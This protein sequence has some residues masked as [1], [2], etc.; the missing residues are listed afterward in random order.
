M[1][2]FKRLIRGIA[3]LAGGALFSQFPGFY[4]AYLQR[5]GGRL[6]QARFQIVRIEEA[7]RAEGYNIANYIAYFR[8]HDG[9]EERHQGEIMIA[10]H[11]DVEHL[12]AALIALGDASLLERPIRL[13]QHFD[14]AYAR[15]TLEEFELVLPL[16][17]EGAV[18]M[19]L[20]LL[21]GFLL[22]RVAGDV[23]VRLGRR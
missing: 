19:V 13:V 23:L 1:A 8:E 16:T 10:Q 7:A 21:F 22:I 17:A 14:A 20:G 6:D 3:A 15:A 12:E 2:M 5:L 9:S 18:Y 4:L 11:A